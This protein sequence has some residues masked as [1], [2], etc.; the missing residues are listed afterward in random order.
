MAAFGIGWKK[1]PTNVEWPKKGG[2]GGG[3]GGGERE[4][5]FPIT[6]GVRD[7]KQY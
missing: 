6:S 2:G 3:G 1:F 7:G 5:S 4:T